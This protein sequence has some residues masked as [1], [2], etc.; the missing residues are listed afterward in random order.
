MNNASFYL[1]GN[2][3]GDIRLRKFSVQE[4]WAWIVLLCLAS[5]EKVRGVINGDDEDIA[6]YCE[7]PGIKEWLC[8]RDKLVAKGML[9]E[10]QGKYRISNWQEFQSPSNPY[11]RPALSEWRII[12][13]RVFARDNH[14]CQYC[15]ATDVKLH[16]DHVVPISRG[17]TNDDDNLVAACETC[18]CQKHDKTPEEWLGGL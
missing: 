13:D 18:N 4:K 5:K 17:G 15:G 3:L 2:L 6:D 8:Y 11:G 12:R 16:C 7:F 1:P 10:H 9:E 14:T